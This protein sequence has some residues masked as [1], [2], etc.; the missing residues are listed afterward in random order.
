MKEMIKA[1]R[2]EIHNMNNYV[3]VIVGNVELILSEEGLS[4]EVLRRIKNINFACNKM[5]D[6]LRK[7]FEILKLDE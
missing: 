5:I 4:E 3:T 2:K 7:S 1:A 6:S